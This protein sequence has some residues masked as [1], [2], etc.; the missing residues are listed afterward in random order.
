[1][2]DRDPAIRPGMT[3]TV[4]IETAT[5]DSVIRIPIQALVARNAERE[6][7]AMERAK[8]GKGDEDGSMNED[9]DD[10]DDPEKRRHEGVYVLN[11]GRALFVPV[12]TGISDDR[13]IEI[14]SGLSSGDRVV[15]GPYQTLRTLTSGKAI[16]EEKKGEE[17]N[18]SA[19]RESSGQ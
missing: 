12:E 9:E 8:A 1:M 6:R 7:S 5:R 19:E 16:R 11:E 10:E 3:A 15:T 14:E 2:N 4:E 17:K 13:H 18:G